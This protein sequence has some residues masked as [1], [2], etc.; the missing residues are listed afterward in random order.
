MR[1]HPMKL[2]LTILLVAMALTTGCAGVNS[3]LQV[4][5]DVLS[6]ATTV[7]IADT[8]DRANATLFNGMVG[9]MPGTF[10]T[11]FDMRVQ[12]T[13]TTIRSDRSWRAH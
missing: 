12:N 10:N 3:S 8:L 5:S 1:R 2:L 6:P 7:A 4:R 9:N 11:R 13:R